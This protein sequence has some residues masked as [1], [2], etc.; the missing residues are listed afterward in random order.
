MATVAAVVS[1]QSGIFV[2]NG[3]VNDPVLIA[4]KPNQAVNFI[5]MDNSSGAAFLVASNGAVGIGALTN[6][7]VFGATNLPP[8]STNL[9]TWVSV[10]I[11]G[12]TNI[13]RL[14]LAK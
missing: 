11:S 1:Q 3:S 4:N 10:Q 12:D 2:V 13:Y 8:V 6:Q 14:G 9:T 7:I 5:E